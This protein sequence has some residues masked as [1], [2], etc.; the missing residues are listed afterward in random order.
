MTAA[1]ARARL[2]LSLVTE[3]G[4]PRL[5]ELL[6]GT[7][8]VDVVRALE[9]GRRHPGVSD[10]W[11]E[12][13]ARA[14]VLVE[15]AR[16]AA[17]AAG[18][19]WVVPG[20]RDWPRGLEDLDHLDPLHGATGCPLGLW[21]RGEASLGELTRHA[22][23]VVGTRSCT[24]YGATTA[25]ELAAD[26]G[27]TGFTVLSGA[28]F[29]IDAAAHRGALAVGRPTIAVLACGADADSPRAHAALLRRIVDAGGLVVSEQP[30]GQVPIRARFLSRNRL[31]AAMTVGTV[32]VEAAR[33]SGSL[34]TLHWADRLGRPT[35]AVPGP[36]TSAQSVGTH[37][38]V[39]DGKAVLV[40]EHRDVLAEL[41]LGPEAAGPGRPEGHGHES[42]GRRTLDALSWDR[43]L[44][45]QEVADRAGAA[46][47]ETAAVLAALAAEGLAVQVD[48]RWLL[49]Q[50]AD[51]T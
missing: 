5:V 51:A 35:M 27:D 38:A 40:T 32:V 16:E 13:F 18:L 3:P 31:I 33:R 30:P 47:G 29:G 25:S 17:E 36:V 8:P 4:D 19:R 6:R 14:D 11:R 22:V 24:S 12:R 49:H 26:L 20:D 42:P 43:A 23:A 46:P 2:V 48:G 1:D 44:P 10:A 9:A 15:R 21:V 45:L 39:R 7:T 28:A 34:N 50:R 41:G 37:Q